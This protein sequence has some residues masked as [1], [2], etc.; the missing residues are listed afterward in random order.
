MHNFYYIVFPLTELLLFRS[1]SLLC[2]Y[3]IYK[4]LWEYTAYK[5][6]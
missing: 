3:E 6:R 5:S 1:S 4:D 2:P